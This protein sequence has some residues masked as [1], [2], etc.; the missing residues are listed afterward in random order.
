[1]LERKR[2]D[3]RT[4]VTFVLPEDTPE[5]PVSVVG[6][7]NHWNPT[8]HPLNPQSDGTRTATVALPAHTSHAFR[9]LAAGDYW[10]DDPT[11]D[12]HDGTNSHLNT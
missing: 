3:G 9:Y 5:G 7:F 6:D 4:Q 8:A 12:H 2:L 10:F 11:A 1:M